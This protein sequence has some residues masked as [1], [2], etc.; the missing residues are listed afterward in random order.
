MAFICTRHPSSPAVDVC[1][2]CSTT[3]C[4][5]CAV[6]TARHQVVCHACA[7]ELAGV[8]H[9]SAPHRAS[10]RAVAQRRRALRTAA[11]QDSTAAAE[12]DRQRIADQAVAVWWQEH[13]ELDAHPDGWTRRF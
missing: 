13:D 2:R 10:R 6:L 5:T 12:T 1:D 11:E 8:H 7:L 4:D 9:R 3:M